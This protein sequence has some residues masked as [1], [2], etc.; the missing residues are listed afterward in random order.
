MHFVEFYRDY[1]AHDRAYDKFKTADFSAGRRS[2]DERR[3]LRFMLSTMNAHLWMAQ[4]FAALSLKD[5]NRGNIVIMWVMQESR[6]VELLGR[7]LCEPDPFPRIP[8]EL[9]GS[10][11]AYDQH[12]EIFAHFGVH[13]LALSLIFRHAGAGRTPDPALKEAYEWIAGA[14]ALER[15]YCFEE[16]R[17]L[18]D[19][20]PARP[21]LVRRTIAGMKTPG[22]ELFEGYEA[23]ALSALKSRASRALL[24]ELAREAREIPGVGG[25]LW[26][27]IQPHLARFG[28]SRLK[29]L[30]A[31]AVLAAV[32]WN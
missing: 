19:F 14:L 21:E 9:I 10:I 30:A 24:K 18:L 3:F 32:S 7:M 8:E 12:A 25:D 23:G 2:E 6:C 17:T 15:R 26:P 4:Q 28:V 1:A 11:S 27:L 22:Q 29:Q 20:D 16:L 13:A 31:R 5:E